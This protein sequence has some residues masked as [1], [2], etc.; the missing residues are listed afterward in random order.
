MFGK[1]KGE[2]FEQCKLDKKCG[3]YQNRKPDSEQIVK[4]K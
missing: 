4:K 2:K 3:K 1:A